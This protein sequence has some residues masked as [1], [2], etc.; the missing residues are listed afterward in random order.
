MP[1]DK[2]DDWQAA[3]ESNINAR[4]Q[5][6]EVS[7]DGEY[8]VKYDAL[9]QRA[10]SDE[11]RIEARNCN[12]DRQNILIR[13]FETLLDNPPKRA[14]RVFVS[15]SHSNTPWLGRLR[16]HLA[17]LRRSNDIETWDDQEI[18]PGEQW[19]KSIK[20]KLAEADVFILL[21]SA[22]F[23]A[24]DYIWDVELKT[25]I[26]KYKEDGDKQV[27]P[28]LIEPL[29]LGGLPGV[30][31]DGTS[32]QSFEIVPK[33]TDGRLQAISLWPNQDEALAKTAERIR[34]AVRS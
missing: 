4:H 15:Y 32:I 22:D 10:N 27:I 24:S 5:L 30:D 11:I 23:I 8:F 14:K 33:N 28:V 26:E 16:N 20:T 34:L 25:A 2:R 3:I 18:L 1:V 19:D 9:R 31:E 7:I 17:G 12:D 13:Q 29:D 21:L 6:L